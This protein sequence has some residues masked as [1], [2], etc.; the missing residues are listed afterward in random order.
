[1]TRAPD[2]R[3]AVVLHGH[4]LRV[5]VVGGGPVAERKAMTFA[6]RGARVRVV[7]P[8]VGDVLRDAAARKSLDV[9]MRPYEPGDLDDVEIVIA[10]TDDRAVNAR[11]ASDARAARRLCNVADAPE[12]GSFSSVAQRAS[13]ALLV[14]VSASGVPAAATRVLDAITSRFDGRYGAA[15]AALHDL[16]QRL[17]KSGD[18]AGWERASS[19]LIA[20]D[21]AERVECGDIAREA[22]E[23]R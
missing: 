14:A 19:R 3:I 1:M 2:T 4:Q 23:W 21:F 10:A 8:R 17:L 15:L 13:G 6:E 18:R 9:S 5:L 12:E 20:D 22:R 7:A 16:R 11:I